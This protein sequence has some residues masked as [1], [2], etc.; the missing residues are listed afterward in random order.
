MSSGTSFSS[1]ARPVVLVPACNRQLGH[2]PF[3]V[4]GQK[5][6]D[7]VRLAGG[8]PLVV[9]AA[10]AHEVDE[11]LA[12]ADGVLLTGSP[13]NVHPRH[14]DQVV[15]DDTLPLDPVRDDWTLPLIPRALALGVPLFAICRGFQEMNVALGGSLHQAVQDQSGLLDHRNDDQ[16]PIDI[17]YGPA[18]PVQ[19]VPGGLLETLLGESEFMVN[20]LHGQGINRLASGLRIEA[21]APDGVVEAVTATAAPRFNLAVQWHPEWRARENPI[22]M[23]L[24]RAFGDAC[25]ERCLERVHRVSTTD[26]PLLPCHLRS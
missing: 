11:L 21:L 7:A 14:F 6:I 20:S 9:P 24:L 19:I 17:Q 13:S 1:V 4:A 15:H 2:H 16:R 3:H 18:H 8:L 12:L 25:R 23:K 22:S 5:Y 26:E 10:G